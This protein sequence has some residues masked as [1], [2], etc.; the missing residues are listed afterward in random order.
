MTTGG[1]ASG[2]VVDLNKRWIVTCQHV[3]GAK[4]EVDIL[5]PAY[6]DGK[7]IQERN[8]Y[9]K[10]A[11]KVKG[12]IL[13]RQQ[14]RSLPDPGGHSSRRHRLAA[15]GGRQRTAWR[16]LEPDRQPGRQ[17]RDVELHHRHPSA[18]YKKKFTYKNTTHEVEAIVGETQ[19]PAN[20]GDS[21]GA[22]FGDQGDVL[23]VHSGGSPDGVQLMASYIDVVEVRRFLRNRSR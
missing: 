7:L 15:D 22:V 14:M 20:P 3:V 8:F 19:S 13:M 11:T 18:V 12:K 16:Q 1:P 9:L 10:T 23:G 5:F 21:G 6:R 2:F 4:E 17:R